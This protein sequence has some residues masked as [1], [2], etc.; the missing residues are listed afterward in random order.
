[1]L[2]ACGSKKEPPAPAPVPEPGPVQAGDPQADPQAGQQIVAQPDFPEGTHS[3]LL[4]RTSAV[5]LEPADDSKRIGTV[6]ID[7]RVGWVRTAGGKGCKK[8][9]VELRPRGWV[10]GDNLEASTKVPFG[11]EVPL[12]ERGEIVPGDYGKVTGPNA[13]TY[14]FEKK[15]SPQKKKFGKPSGPVVSPSEVEAPQKAPKLVEDKPVLG[16]LTVRLYEE[17]TFEGRQYYRINA[18][19]KEYVLKSAV[20]R[21]KPSDYMGSRLGDDTGWVLPFAFVWPRNNWLQAWTYH[22]P[23]RVV[24]RQIAARTPVPILEVAEG[25]DKKPMAYRIGP[26]EWIGV[27]DVRV[28]TPAAAPPPYLKPGERWIDIDLD[29]QMLVA[30]EGGTAVYATLVSSGAKDH[31]TAPG[32]YRMWLKESEADMKNLK[33]ED[34]YS[35][36][37]V[38]WTQF[39]FP[40][41]DLA[42]HTAYWHDQ[43]GKQRSRGCVNLAPRDARWLYYWSDPQVPPGWTMATGVVEMPGSVVRV[44]SAAD[45]NPEWK[46]YAKKV[47]E[48]RQLNA[49]R[50]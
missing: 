35:V 15:P 46:G 33:S 38:P 6:A 26:E 12:L 27:Q 49:P 39:F 20:S 28:F 17:A 14:V 21:S 7:T 19:D 4:T 32:L 9:W 23:N 36:A 41:D 29:A 40:D 47:V 10:C 13:V 16:S 25:K 45:P 8:P 5:R 44:R 3:L 30:F 1:L 31:P 24:N 2:A 22:Q 48:A 43:F 34:P 18:K 11:R 37:T 42:L 50:P